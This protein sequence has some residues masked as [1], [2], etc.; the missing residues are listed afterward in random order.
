MKHGQTLCPLLTRLFMSFVLIAHYD[1]G[2]NW[3]ASRFRFMADR[4]G[5]VALKALI[6]YVQTTSVLWLTA[7]APPSVK[8]LS[9]TEGSCKC[10]QSTCL[11]VAANA[12]WYVSDR[13]T[14][15]RGFR[16]S[17]TT[18]KHWKLRLRIKWCREPLG[19]ATW[20]TSGAYHGLSEVTHG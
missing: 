11:H 16:Y 9:A 2:I 1:R 4:S 14:R 13:F 19:S 7:H 8:L 15:L 20:K 12:P 18:S 5:T 6:C 10:W 17:W 3:S